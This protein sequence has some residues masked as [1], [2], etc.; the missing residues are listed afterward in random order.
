MLGAEACSKDLIL[1]VHVYPIYSTGTHKGQSAG[2]VV[3]GKS[4]ESEE[5]RVLH[6]RIIVVE[7]LQWKHDVKPHRL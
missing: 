6:H 1:Y 5:N 2:I 7:P 3:S 4:K